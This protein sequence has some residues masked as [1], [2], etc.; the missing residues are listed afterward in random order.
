MN[1]L[2]ISPSKDHGIT[3]NIPDAQIVEESDVNTAVEILYAEEF[4]IDLVLVKGPF[5]WQIIRRTCYD[6][7]YT[8]PKV[9]VLV[10]V[11]AA[12]VPNPLQSVPAFVAASNNER[13]HLALLREAAASIN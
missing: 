13:C 6:F 5:S 7:Y 2:V 3:S 8:A 10:L 9:P 12:V 11:E 1:I 4:Q